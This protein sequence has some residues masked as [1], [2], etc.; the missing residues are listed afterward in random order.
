MSALADFFFI[1]GLANDY[2]FSSNQVPKSNE[3][4]LV[5][6]RESRGDQT[7]S[8]LQQWHRISRDYSISVQGETT[9]VRESPRER[10]SLSQTSIGTSEKLKEGFH[11][12]GV[13]F[14]SHAGEV[15]P[16]GEDGKEEVTDRLDKSLSFTPI[17]VRPGNTLIRKVSNSSVLKLARRMSFR[18]PLLDNSPDQALS[19][20]RLHAYAHCKT[21]CL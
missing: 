18:I 8:Q 15:I 10:S 17:L 5:V 6:I 9:T 20:P 19:R 1:A 4:E 12:S 11:T 21:S 13:E 7:H 16:P 3:D 2:D 14:T